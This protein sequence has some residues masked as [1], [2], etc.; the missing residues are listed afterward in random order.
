MAQ[1]K[2]H[3]DMLEAGVAAKISASQ[4]GQAADSGKLVQ[5]TGAGVIPSGYLP[6][7]LPLAAEGELTM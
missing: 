4:T 1:S 5:L 2:V 7:D 3:N 6:N